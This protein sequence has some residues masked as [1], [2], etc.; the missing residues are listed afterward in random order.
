ME[1]TFYFK[2]IQERGFFWIWQIKEE[3]RLWNVINSLSEEID[4]HGKSSWWNF[5]E[6]REWSEEKMFQRHSNLILK[7]EKEKNTVTRWIYSNFDLN[8]LINPI[9]VW[10]NHLIQYDTIV[11]HSDRS[12][13]VNIVNA[14]RM[15]VWQSPCDPLHTMPRH[16]VFL[17]H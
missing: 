16:K 7:K 10:I 1:Y 13:S 4:I 2:E 9:R 3:I 15:H 11:K 8:K 12:K 14:A 6:R 17:L 5:I